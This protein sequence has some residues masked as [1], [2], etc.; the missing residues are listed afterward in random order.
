MYIIL[1]RVWLV[2]SSEALCSEAIGRND[3]CC[4]NHC[5]YIMMHTHVEQLL[6]PHN[7]SHF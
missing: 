4:D 3:A 1:T 6:V 2:P 5:I 7:R